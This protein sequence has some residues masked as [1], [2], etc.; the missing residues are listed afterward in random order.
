MYV[1]VLACQPGTSKVMQITDTHTAFRTCDQL[2][3]YGC[4]FTVH[5]PQ[6]PDS[7]TS[8]FHPFERRNKQLACKT[9]AT[10]ADVKQAVTSRLQIIDINF[11]QTGLQ[12]LVSWWQKIRECL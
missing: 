5:S 12:A 6:R 11:F 1:G 8:D 9:F 3:R 2:W 4:N 7:G 10:D